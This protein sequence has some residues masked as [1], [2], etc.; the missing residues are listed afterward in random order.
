MLINLEE[1][2][3]QLRDGDSDPET[4]N[5]VFRAVHSIKGG[6]GAFGFDHLVS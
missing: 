4:L 5:S 6:A 2:L 3:M 1:G